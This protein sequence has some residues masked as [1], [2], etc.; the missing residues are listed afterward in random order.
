MVLIATRGILAVSWS[1]Y[2]VRSPQLSPMT[3]LGG[4]SWMPAAPRFFTTVLPRFRRPYRGLQRRH[5]STESFWTRFL[6]GS[7]PRERTSPLWMLWDLQIL[8]SM[9]LVR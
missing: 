3:H 4:A 9:G 1:L 8:W 6:H 5:T 2:P 7:M